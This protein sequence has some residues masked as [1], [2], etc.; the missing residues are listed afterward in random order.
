[1]DISFNIFTDTA[2]LVVFDL[3]S[4]RHRLSD[5]PDW[6]SLPEDELDEINQGNAVFLNLGQDGGYV[7]E[8][9]DN[10]LDY[11]GSVYIRVLSGRIFV[12]AGEDVTGG[13]LEPDDTAAV[14]GRLI[15]MAPGSYAVRFRRDGDV[16][17]LS[18]V[19]SGE[20]RNHLAGPVRL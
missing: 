14:S 4:L 17:S 7:V 18:F 16:I 2:T 15:E 5:T 13:D 1:M 3:A 11:S 9:V 10:L 8:I 20:F 19:I 6:W 12:G